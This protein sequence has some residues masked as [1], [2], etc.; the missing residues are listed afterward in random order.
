MTSAYLYHILRFACGGGYTL[1]FGIM[2]KA[3]PGDATEA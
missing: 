2:P 1:I 3:V